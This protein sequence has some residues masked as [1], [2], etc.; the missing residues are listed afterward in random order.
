MTLH[1]DTEVDF[2]V[3]D[4]YQTRHQANKVA[5]KLEF[6]NKI[7]LI[8]QKFEHHITEEPVCDFAYPKM[9]LFIDSVEKMKKIADCYQYVDDDNELIEY[10]F[11]NTLRRLLEDEYGWN[12]RDGES[13]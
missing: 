11:T 10:N 9:K 13:L 5:A 7:E 3:G 6:Y 12:I 8:K 2:L 1:N 4:A